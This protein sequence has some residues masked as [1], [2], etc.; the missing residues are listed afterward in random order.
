MHKCKYGILKFQKYMYIH[1]SI[2]FAVYT[3]LEMEHMECNNPY[4]ILTFE[5]LRINDNCDICS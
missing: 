5:C 3:E 4:N 1:C 2:Q